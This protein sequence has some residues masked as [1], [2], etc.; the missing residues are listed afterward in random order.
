MPVKFYRKHKNTI[1]KVVK[2]AGYA[3]QAIQLASKVAAL[4]NV[5]YKY[6]DF[7]QSGTQNT[8]PSI[9][10]LTGIPQGDSVNERVGNSIALKNMYMKGL[11]IPTG[12][13]GVQTITRIIMFMDKNSNNSTAP[14]ASNLLADTGNP[15]ISFIN[16]DQGKR[17][18]VLYDKL[19]TFEQFNTAPIKLKLYRE[20]GFKKTEN[21]QVKQIQQHITWQGVNAGDTEKG[22]IYL[23]TVSNQPTYQPTIT[24][25]TRFNY[26]DN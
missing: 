16:K 2:G 22:H 25:N 5:E 11:V 24:L 4:I 10:L 17:F 12:P 14:T 26:I 7:L 6:F 19:H 8:T 3:Y 18:K 13:E 23:M 21:N 20:F 15:L 1:R 9:T